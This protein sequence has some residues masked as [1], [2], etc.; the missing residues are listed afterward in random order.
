MYKKLGALAI[1]LATSFISLAPGYASLAGKESDTYKVEH[2]QKKFLT[3]NLVDDEEQ[4]EKNFLAMD[5][6]NDPWSLTFASYTAIAD[7]LDKICA[8]IMRE[9]TAAAEA[10]LKKPIDPEKDLVMKATVKKIGG[11]LYGSTGLELRN[12]LQFADTGKYRPLE[13]AVDKIKHTLLLGRKQKVAE[14]LADDSLAKLKNF[15]LEVVAALRNSQVAHS[16]FVAFA[17]EAQTISGTKPFCF[18]WMDNDTKQ[19]IS[20]AK[21]GNLVTLQMRGDAGLKAFDSLYA[22]EL[23]AERVKDPVYIIN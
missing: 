6:T 18:S 17:K 7:C 11:N 23:D 12:P 5:P 4:L 9:N 21:W 2:L 3:L 8:D 15:G 19:H 13:L 16:P 10:S 20:V 22:I 14:P 1:F